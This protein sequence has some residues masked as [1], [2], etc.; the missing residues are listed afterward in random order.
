M[1]NPFAF[2][3]RHTAE[4]TDFFGR[5]RHFA[6]FT[7]ARK[8]LLRRLLA[9]ATSVVQ[10]ERGR[11][12]GIHLAVAAREEDAGHLFRVVLVHLAAERFKIKR[13]AV[14]RAVGKVSVRDGT[15]PAADK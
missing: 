12:D 13:S 3:L 6:Q 5:A 2:L 4:D 9:D 10:N 1:K 14:R 11:F 7:E 15:S 8:N